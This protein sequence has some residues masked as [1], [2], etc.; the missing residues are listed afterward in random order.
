LPHLHD[1]LSQHFGGIPVLWRL[2]GLIEWEAC[3]AWDR[4]VGVQSNVV[5]RLYCRV[6]CKISLGMENRTYLL[7]IPPGHAWPDLAQH[8]AHIEDTV[9]HHTIGGTLDLEVSEE[10]VGAEE[11]ENLVQGVVR[12]V[13]GIDGELCHV[14]GEERQLDGG[15]TGARPEREEGKV[16]YIESE[17]LRC[18]V[19]GVIPIS[20]CFGSSRKTEW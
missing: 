1:V 5:D 20:C 9:D 7:R 11:S 17:L 12:L 14:C 3:V 10:G 6:S 16:A 2:E 15:S 19:Q 18:F 8:F 13:C 4:E